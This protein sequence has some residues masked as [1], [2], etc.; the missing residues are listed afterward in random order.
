LICSFQKHN[1]K[2]NINQGRLLYYNHQVREG[3]S[4]AGKSKAE[5]SL[6][7]AGSCIRSDVN[8]FPAVGTNVIINNTN[9][10]SDKILR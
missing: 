4:R 7:L 9:K 2:V 6:Q 8:S 5:E 3:L 10:V 1:E